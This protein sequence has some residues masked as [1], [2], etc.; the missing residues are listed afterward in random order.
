MQSHN[1]WCIYKKIGSGRNT[2][3]SCSRATPKWR[4]FNCTDKICCRS[5]SQ[6]VHWSLVSF[7]VSH[8]KSNCCITT[9]F[10]FAFYGPRYRSSPGYP[11]ENLI[12]VDF[13]SMKYR[14][15]TLK[16]FYRFFTDTVFHM[17]ESYWVLFLGWE[18]RTYMVN[19][20]VTIFGTVNTEQN[21]FPVWVKFWADPQRWN[22]A[23]ILDHC[24]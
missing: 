5:A 16:E 13:I 14:F 23:T 17:K 15:S 8:S 22:T 10:C 12:G 7:A 11:A 21:I 9:Q 18:Y 24:W 1:G 4:F 3:Y 2:R 20:A 6:F 19:C